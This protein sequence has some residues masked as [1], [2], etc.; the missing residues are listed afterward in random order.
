ML[1]KVLS[2]PKMTD[3]LLSMSAL[4]ADA[5]AAMIRLL[6][7]GL[8][9]WTTND[10]R[11]L[12]ARKEGGVFEV[13][14]ALAPGW[15]MTAEAQKAT[16]VSTTADDDWLLWHAR[17]GHISKSSMTKLLHASATTG[18]PAGLKVSKSDN[19]CEGC[20]KGKAH[21]MAFSNARSKVIT[22]PC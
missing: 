14:V 17:C 16:I 6:P 10:R 11:V 1:N 9:M 3:N 12:E 18:L 8:D 19:V 15:A 20:E 22:R 7:K 21:R 5:R 2:H 13:D 4:Q